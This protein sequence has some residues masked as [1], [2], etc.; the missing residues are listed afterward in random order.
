MFIPFYDGKALQHVSLQW[1]TLSIIAINVVVFLIG[2]PFAPSDGTAGGL[3]IGF[4][5]IP[6]VANDLRTLPTEFRYIPDGLYPLTAITYSF[7]HADWWHLAGNMLFIW[8]FGDNV[9][10]AMGHIKFL[11]FYLA[12]AVAG[13]FFH[14][15]V[16]PDSSSPLI[17]ASGAAAGIVAAYLMLH[18]KARVWVLVMMRIPIRLTALWVLGFWIAFQIFMFV[19]SS[20]QGVSWAAHVGGIMAGAVLVV[21][22]KRRNVELFDRDLPVPQNQEA[23]VEPIPPKPKKRPWGRS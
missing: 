17:G 18:P 7:L 1:V 13:A 5:H 20:G 8:V 14:A 12:C 6:S 19:T 16:F 2:L 21:I 9:E 11:I 10:D 23:L 3:A 22:L 15:L 4:G